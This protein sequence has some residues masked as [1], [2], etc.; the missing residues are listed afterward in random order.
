MKKPQ[1]RAW[2]KAEKRM[3]RDVCISPFHVGDCDRLLWNYDDVVLM[4]NTGLKLILSDYSTIDIYEGDVLMIGSGENLVV[5]WNHE[6]C[7][8]QLEGEFTFRTFDKIIM[9]M[10]T[11]LGNIF[12]NQE[13]SPIRL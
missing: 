8:F 5:I 1:F 2:V 9:T 13:L 3:V 4:M 6:R 7:Q 11:R 10:A 12:E